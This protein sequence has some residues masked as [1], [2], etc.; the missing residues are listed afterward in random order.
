MS[1][2]TAGKKEKQESEAPCLLESAHCVCPPRNLAV[3]A[4]VERLVGIQISAHPLGI[5][6]APG[7]PY[8]PMP[9]SFQEPN[10]K[11]GNWPFLFSSSRSLSWP[12]DQMSLQGCNPHVPQQSSLTYEKAGA[13]ASGS[14]ALCYGAGAL[15]QRKACL[16]VKVLL[17][18]CVRMCGCAF[19][20]A[21]SW[22]PH[23][24]LR[25]RKTFLFLKTEEFDTQQCAKGHTGHL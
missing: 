15:G 10:E 12:S 1:S 5:S 22:Q 18:V 20:C 7:P 19:A 24:T 6:R 14:R 25:V 8:S 11:A 17:G 13:T 9:R 21:C 23:I 2:E 16:K 4:P 3:W